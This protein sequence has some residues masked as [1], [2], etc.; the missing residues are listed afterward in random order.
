MRGNVYNNG[1]PNSDT[2]GYGVMTPNGGQGLYVKDGRLIN[3]G[4]S[5]EMTG[6]GKM[7]VANTAR[8]RAEK[9]SM[10]ADATYLGY[11]RAEMMERMNGGD[12]M[13][14]CY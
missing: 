4:P 7:S 12:C 5:E 11:S 2:S 13:G 14:G 3:T 1:D 8:K 9:I 10:A 6:I